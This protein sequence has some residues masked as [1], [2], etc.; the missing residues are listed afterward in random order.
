MELR[1]LRYFVTVAEELNITNAAAKLNISQP[2]LSAQ[3]KNLEYELNT[4][5]FIR[6]KRHLQLTESGQLLYR[7]A[8]ELVNL[9]DKA[10]EEILALNSGLSGTIAM[11]VVEGTASAIAA[12]WFAGF[13]QENPQVRFRI[14]NGGSD[15]LI[16]KMRGG[17]ISLAVISA[18]FDQI[19]LNSIP[20]GSEAM[21]AFIGKGHPLAAL[22]GDSLSIA[23]LKDE[24]L[25]VPARRSTVEAV[26]KWFR[27]AR[28]E[29]RIVCE[30]ESCL[31]AVA[32]AAQNAG[33]SILPRT[34]SVKNDAVVRKNIAGEDKRVA[35]HFVWRKGHPLPAAEERLIDF[36]KSRQKEGRGPISWDRSRVVSFDM[37]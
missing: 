5:L 9:A 11:G 6:G 1:T 14:V 25:I 28:S 13:L 21:A 8:K 17:L 18:P 2:P 32:L 22:P 36:I 19:L 12:E 26:Y 27:A 23:A 37:P 29:P 16:E 15:E 24:P 20:V 3:I 4:V 31:D 7:R 30:T 34:E 10:K 33:V 35:Y